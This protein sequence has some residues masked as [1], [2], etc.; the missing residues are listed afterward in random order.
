METAPDSSI[1]MEKAVGEYLENPSKAHLSQLVEAGRKLVY[2]FASLY[3]PGH[4]RDDLCQAGFEGLLKAARSFDPSRGVAFSTYASH[5]ILG[6][7]RHFVRKETSYYRPGCIAELQG[8]VDAFIEETLKATGEAPSLEAIASALNVREE[9]VVQAMRAGR[10]SLEE[11][12]LSKIHSQRYESF[13]LPI[14][15]RIALEQALK[16]LGEVQ[17][18][19]VFLLYYRDMTQAQV[20]SEL[21][22]S[23]RKVSRLLHKSLKQMLKTLA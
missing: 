23:Q 18:K 11:V 4:P 5:L 7:I 9:G 13:R 6:E 16:R 15:D 20:A 12:D 17:R 14:E 22:I 3:T 10:V 21:G 2:H 8:R 19:V 1:C